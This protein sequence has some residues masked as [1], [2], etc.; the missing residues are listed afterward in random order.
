MKRE[1]IPIKPGD[2]IRCPDRATARWHRVVRVGRR[3][4]GTRYIV[5]RRSRI[6]RLLGL[7]AKQVLEWS[8][9]RAI[10]YGLK[11]RV[12]GAPGVEP[13]R[14]WSPPPPPAEATS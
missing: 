6:G 8:H 7:P 11:R 9:V 4:D 5:L 14:P 1:R 3:R 12:E 2:Y 10:G 13:V